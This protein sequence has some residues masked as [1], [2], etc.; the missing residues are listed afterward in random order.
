MCNS[1]FGSQLEYIESYFEVG[2]PFISR[3]REASPS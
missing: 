1:S 2:H 3:S